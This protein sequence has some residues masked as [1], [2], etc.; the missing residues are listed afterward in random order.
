MERWGTVISWNSKGQKAVRRGGS[1]ATP[2]TKESY[3]Q[4]TELS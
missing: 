2:T 3:P 4:G 1:Q